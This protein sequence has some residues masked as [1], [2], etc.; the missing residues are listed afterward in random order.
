MMRRD[1]EAWKYENGLRLD[2]VQN[3]ERGYVLLGTMSMLEF[4]CVG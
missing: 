4:S 1:V 2:E 3:L